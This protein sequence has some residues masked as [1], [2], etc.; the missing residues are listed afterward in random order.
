MIAAARLPLRSDPADSQFERPSAH[1]RI[2][3]HGSD[4]SKLFDHSR[5]ST[6][7]SASKASA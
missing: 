7:M 5:M 3:D 2:C 6:P 1:G 4:Y